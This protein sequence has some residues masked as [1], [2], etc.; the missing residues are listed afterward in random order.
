MCNIVYCTITYHIFIFI[1]TRSSS[2]PVVN[3]HRRL[4]VERSAFVSLA[5]HTSSFR[6]C[7]SLCSPYITPG[8]P[9][10]FL[11]VQVVTSIPLDFAFHV[12]IAPSLF[13][14]FPPLFPFLPLLASLIH[15]PHPFLIFSR[16]SPLLVSLL[17]LVAHV[18][19]YP[20]LPS[21]FLSHTQES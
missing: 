3:R 2:F 20:L 4:P 14:A 1:F 8:Q 12:H 21:S 6:P 16:R 10:F 19:I 17:V 18:H 15:S 11:V 9:L 7:L 5:S 13:V